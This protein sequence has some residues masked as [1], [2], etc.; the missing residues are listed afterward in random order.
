MTKKLKIAFQGEPGANSHIAIVEAYPD[1][2]PVPCPTFEDA[3][4]A[5][6]SESVAT[7]TSPSR[8]ACAR[9]ITCTIIGSPAMSRSGLPGS[10]V[11]AMRA[12]MRM[13]TSAIARSRPAGGLRARSGSA[14]HP[15]EDP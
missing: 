3:L 13:R 15:E 9:R 2:E 8:A 11:E 6:T 14:P 4:A 5:I 10:L 7:T 1:A 12:G